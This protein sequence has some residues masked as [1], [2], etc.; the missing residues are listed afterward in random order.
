[1]TGGRFERLHAQQ[2]RRACVFDGI[3]C[4]EGTIGQADSIERIHIGAG[5]QAGSP[6]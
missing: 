5:R 1:M 6:E 2:R 3:W 4:S